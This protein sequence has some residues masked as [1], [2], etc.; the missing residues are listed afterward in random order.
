VDALLR[1]TSLITRCF[2]ASIFLHAVL[3]GGYGA[4]TAPRVHE[5]AADTAEAED[6]DIEFKDIPPELFGG[7]KSPVK[8]E[9]S[10][11]VEGKSKN[12][13]DSPDN[14]IKVNALSGDGTDE[15]GYLFA[16]R[17]DSPPVPIIDFDLKDYY[18]DEAR[19]ANIR[20]KT[21]LVTVQVD[22]YGALK[23]AR[24][25]TGNAGF[26]FDEAALMVMRRVRFRPGFKK[27]VPIKMNHRLAVQFVLD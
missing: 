27:G 12:A 23:S 18:P 9:K 3:A 11:W 26:G 19:R 17:G 16:I 10:E 8:I 25:L 5:W 7:D 21:V 1:N 6:V 13:D 24:L 2:M 15:D 4:F 22:E 20:K 14:D